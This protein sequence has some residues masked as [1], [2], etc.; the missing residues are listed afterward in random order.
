MALPEQEVHF[1]FAGG[2][3]TKADPKAVPRTKLLALENGVFTRAISIQKRNGYDDAGQAIDGS[4]STI[5][6]AIRMAARGNELLEFAASRCYSR[7]TGASQWSDAGAVYSAVGTDR[8]LVVTGTQQTMPD[9]ATLAGVTVAAWEDSQGGVWWSTTDAT[10]ER[11]YRAPTQAHASGISPRCVAVGGNLHVYYAVV[12]TKTIYV[13]V[14]NPAAPSAAVSPAILTATIDGTDC[15]YDACPTTRTGTPAAMAWCEDGTTA[16][17]IGY[18][19]QSGVLGVPLLGHPSVLTIAAS[20]RVGTPLGLTHFTFDGANGDR[21][22][23]AYVT[24]VPTSTVLILSGGSGAG[25][26]IAVLNTFSAAVASAADLVR[27]AVAATS[28]STAWTAWES[29]AA[30]ASNHFVTSVAI[31]FATGATG[32]AGGDGV[33][34]SMCLVSRAFVIGG[35]AFACM[36][37]DTTFFN[38]YVTYRF[39]SLSGNGF[40]PVG[41]HV[42]ASAAG[43]PAR[44]HLA[45]AHASGSVI[46][47]TVGFRERLISENDDKFQETAIQLVTMDFDSQASH[48]AVEYGRGL[49]MAG[50]C[51]MHYDGRIWTELGFHVGP[52]LIATVAAGG[53]SMTSSTTY[54]YRSWYEWTDSQGEI[55]LGPTS[56]GTLV[57][58]GGG[59]TQVTLTLPPC[60]ATLK[61]GVRIGVARSL[62][63]K[64][65]DT[66]Q[67]FRVT[68]LDPTTVGAANGY[69]ANDTTVD[70]VSF[71]DRMSDTTLATFDELYTDGGIL[72]NDPTPL[73]SAMWRGKDRLFSTDPTDGTIVRYSQPFSDGFGVQWPPDLFLRVDLQGGDVVAGASRDNREIVWTEGAIFTFA[74]DGPDNAGSI[75]VTGFSAV[76]TIP[77]DVGCTDPA[78]VVLTPDGHMFKSGKGIYRLS[79]DAT[80]EYVGA[81]VEAF[82]AQTVRRAT[83]LPNRTQVVFL[84]D[85]GSTLLFDY[86]FNQWSTFTNHEG[87][88][89]A[90]VDGQYYYLRADGRVFRETVGEYSDAG[91]R[92]RLRF[93]TAW[94]HLAE[95]LQGFQSFSNIHLLGT[96]ISAHQLGVQYQTDYTLG[97]T[98]PAW[99]DATGASS[100]TGWITGSFANTVGVEPI[101]G[102]NYNDGLYDDGQYGGTGPGEYAWRIDIYETGQSVQLRF[103]DFEAAGFAGASFE[104]TEL[105]VTGTVIGNV[106]RPMTAGRSA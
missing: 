79:N 71:L 11:V 78:S 106:R 63:A 97:W 96:W 13:I 12:S 38:T 75:D 103:E 93:E 45:S 27:V 56:A 15:V 16:I 84:T 23:L 102:T 76:Q 30:A 5:T 64:T 9:H 59:D 90:V 44:K 94:I 20:R 3:E 88:D 22:V 67:L 32:P 104:L 33:I 69:V 70:T 26:P 92:I 87:L 85:S 53:G 21:F 57:T 98:D 58:M 77:S 86:L 1:A 37:H 40:V 72:S 66:A 6:G 73:G 18:V 47:F 8:P 100:S 60:R 46:N 17:R 39:S 31:D 36:A 83:T 65:G 51:P 25:T 81:A 52:E 89:A 62:A 48:Q 14:V 61:P 101:A 50:A 55:H 2:V 91:Q 54:L 42:P 74:G 99:L 4:S 29:T 10:S 95:H 105:V 80:V 24:A 82:N 34:R 19:D 41:R 7:E 43:A 28:S 35:E 68:S 49:Y